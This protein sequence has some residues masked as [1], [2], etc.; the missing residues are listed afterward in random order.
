MNLR[1]QAKE[2]CDLGS[3]IRLSSWSIRVEFSWSSA[4]HPTG[5]HDA[6][7]AS[8]SRFAGE[9]CHMKMDPPIT[10]TDRSSHREPDFYRISALVQYAFELIDVLIEKQL[11]LLKTKKMRIAAQAYFENTAVREN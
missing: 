7:D 1:S 6:P 9:L 2:S 5:Q 8:F 4:E 3:R 11:C 10:E